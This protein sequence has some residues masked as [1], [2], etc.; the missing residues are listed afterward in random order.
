MEFEVKLPPSQ[1]TFGRLPRVGRAGFHECQGLGAAHSRSRLFHPTGRGGG[2]SPARDV[3]EV[4][5]ANVSIVPVK[6]GPLDP[7]WA[8]GTT[9][10]SQGTPIL[11]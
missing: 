6:A 3:I 10:L 4:G 8:K 11:V 1:I 7:G 9:H 2:G 5:T